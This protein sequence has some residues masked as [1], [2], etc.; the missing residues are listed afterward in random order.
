M[1]VRHR[2]VYKSIKKL[3]KIIM[4][5]HLYM[6]KVENVLV[7]LWFCPFILAFSCNGCKRTLRIP[8][9]L[10]CPLFLP[11]NIRDLSLHKSHIFWT[12]S[13][14]FTTRYFWKKHCRPLRTNEILDFM[15]YS[16]R[17]ASS[18][19]ECLSTKHFSRRFQVFLPILPGLCTTFDAKLLED[20]ATLFFGYTEKC[21]RHASDGQHSHCN[22]CLFL[23]NIPRKRL[24]G[25][26]HAPSSNAP[27]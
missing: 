24:Q 19:A 25:C 4:A 26:A 1:L 2:Q 22:R 13:I 23:I 6:S 9:A 8:L 5:S 10:C 21:L 12:L 18:L 17:K 7:K 3:I 15:K 20:V 14:R 11:D 27:C 16:L